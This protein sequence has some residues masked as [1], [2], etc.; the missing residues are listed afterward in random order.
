MHAI[1]RVRPAPA[2]EGVAAVLGLVGFVVV[3][4]GVAAVAYAVVEKP[5]ERWLRGRPRAEDA[6]GGPAARGT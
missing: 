2:L 1:G 6:V 3:A 5:A 4:T